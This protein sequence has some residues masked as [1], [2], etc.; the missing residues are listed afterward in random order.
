MK[1][2]QFDVA[3]LTFECL[4]PDEV[5]AKS[6]LRSYLPFYRTERV[7]Q[8]VFSLS[9]TD[10]TPDIQSFTQTES[11][12]NDLGDVVV[13]ENENSFAFSINYS[14]SGLY[15]YL[16]ADK[17]FV[18]AQAYISF[19]DIYASTALTSMLRI[20]YSQSVIKY[21]G[22]S[23]HSSVVTRDGIGYLFLG[24]SGTGKS[25]HTRL[26]LNT[27]DGTSLLNDDNPICRFIDDKLYVF[28]SPWSGKTPCY[29]NQRAVV[30]SLVR[31]EQYPSNIFNQ[32]KGIV[33]WAEIFP[34]CSVLKESRYLYEMAITTVN[35]IVSTCI[36]G[37][38]KCLPDKEA[39]EICEMSIRHLAENK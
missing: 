6:L 34:S 19:E 8:I 24:K 26:W 27:I 1:R 3:E 5:N 30:S 12:S 18:I 4:L 9:V 11:F 28:G 35:R 36:I 31:L 25:T 33:A 39:A 38:M 10:H 7:D 32:L 2:Y 21:D 17:Q 22:I 16:V 37:H 13:Y 29:K 20:L 23:I 14:E 15:H